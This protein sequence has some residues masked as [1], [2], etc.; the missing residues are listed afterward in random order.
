MKKKL[1]LSSNAKNAHGAYP[2]PFGGKMLR[3]VCTVLLLLCV[4]MA[5]WADTEKFVA[6]NASLHKTYFTDASWANDNGNNGTDFE[7]G[8][9]K[10]SPSTVSDSTKSYATYS[11]SDGGTISVHINAAKNSDWQAQVHL[12]TDITFDASKDYDISFTITPQNNNEIISISDIIVK[13]GDVNTLYSPAEDKITTTAEVAYTYSHTN[14]RGQGGNDGLLIFDFGHSPANTNITISGISII[15]KE[16][17][18]A[19]PISY[20]DYATG[21]QNNAS[22]D[23]T[24]GRILLSLEPTGNTNEYKLTIKPNSENG[25]TSKFD[26]LYVIATGNSPYPAEAGTD[27]NGNEFA[28]MSVTFTNSN[29]TTSFMV[30]YSNPS[31]SGRHECTLTDV[32]LSTLTSCTPPSSDVEKPDM[33]SATATKVSNTHNQVVIEISDA[34]DNVG[35]TKYVVKNQSDASSVGEY[36]PTDNKITVT[37]LSPETS[38]NWDIYAKDA[39]GNVSDDAVKISFTTD[40]LAANYCGTTLTSG[41]HSIELT[42]QLVNGNYR[43]IIEGENLNG[44]GGSFYNSGTDLRTKITSSTSTR[45][46]CDLDVE[47][48]FDNPLYVMMPNEVTFSWP[49]DVVW[50]T[51]SAV[52][53]TGVSLN[54][55]TLAMEVGGATQTLTATVAPANA[56]NQ[57][58]TWTSS[59]T[60][61]ATVEDGVVT[62]VAAG[63]ATITV[64]TEEG[65]FTAT[66]DVTVSVPTFEKK[67]YY[68]YGTTDIKNIFVLYSVSRNT[69]QTLTFKLENYEYLPEYFGFV[70]PHVFVGGSDLGAMSL[71]EGKY[72]F[73]TEDTYTANEELSCKFHFVYGNGGDK[74]IEFDYTVAA[75]NSIP[76]VNAEKVALSSYA[77][78]LAIGDDAVITATVYPT[79]ASSTAVDWGS[80][81]ETVAT[82]SL[83]TI[84][85]E[86]TGSTNITATCGTAVGTCAVTV[87]ETLEEAKYY[88]A[89]TFTNQMESKDAFAYE[90]TFTRATN[91][92][93]RLDVVFSEDMTPYINA[94]N[95]QMYVNS[96]LQHM[97]YN[98]DTKTATYNFGSQSEDAGISY[99]FYFVMNGGGVHQ[100]ANAT[101][102]VGS[103]NEK[104]YA[105]VVDEDINNDATL[106]AYNNKTADVIIDRSFTADNLYTLVLPFDVD[107]AR[108][109]EKLPG[110]ITRLNNT[111]VK[112]NDDLRLNFVDAASIEAGVPYLYTPS[113]N[114]TNPVFNGVTINKNL[115][116]TVPADGKA[117]Y[118]GIYAPT[119]GAW[120]K[121]QANAYVLGS[122]RY[123]YDVQALQDDQP[124]NALRGY[125]VLNFESASSVAPRAR[126]I[127]NSQ[128]TEVATGN[129]TPTL[130]QG[131]GVK[132]LRDGQLL[133]IRDGRTYNAQGQLIK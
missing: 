23:D 90:Y 12:Q 62:A 6:A 122:D 103:P 126:V 8:K 109:A 74:Y 46:V 105:C 32:P 72:T 87:S 95:F 20:C 100:T 7:D 133:I 69:N 25:N 68:A 4:S 41:D 123:L 88:G 132:V 27:D 36:A 49:D 86:A 26:Y 28:E 55:T 96:T 5:G 102:T 93:V 42:C 61:V 75:E 73:T 98:A 114:V 120:L 78:G 107:A 18:P 130:S 30:Q 67:V 37:D 80:D 117:E 33:S 13:M 35:I 47:P 52:A 53:V 17:A 22:C 66:C 38:Y 76:T 85:A 2:P 83:G 112:E 3:G 77:E 64:T 1:S 34:T 119:T 21:H 110:T 89:G 101:Y 29:A 54:E 108:T 56:T 99:Y 14:V 9:G 51:C 121:T 111:I 84:H 92:E 116:P 94:D 60:G 65:S 58:V 15:E 127:F 125:F 113:A 19:E 81:N 43:I 44:L 24:R 57:N 124:M 39:A 45:I 91:H 79:F 129:L 48:T 70:E 106:T 63:T 82:V 16:P 131:E 31:W 71:V 104:V 115:N 10:L 11:T 59:N 128:E 118:H 50:G 97:T 40:A